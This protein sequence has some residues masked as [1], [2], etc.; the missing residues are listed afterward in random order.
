MALNNTVP[1]KSPGDLHYSSEVNEVTTFQKKQGNAQ[2]VL[3]PANILIDGTGQFNNYNHTGATLTLNAL[4]SVATSGDNYKKV[5]ITFTQDCTV[6]FTGEFDTDQLF[7]LPTGNVFPDGTYIFVFNHDQINSKVGFI[8]PG[9][10]GGVTPPVAE[11]TTFNGTT[12]NINFGDILD[13]IITGASARFAVEFEMKDYSESGY[14]AN[15]YPT[16]PNGQRQFGI[17]QFAGSMY[18]QYSIDGTGG[19]GSFNQCIWTGMTLLEKKVRIEF[20]ASQGGTFGIDK[21]TLYIDDVLYTTGKN[22]SESF[23]VSNIGTTTAQLSVGCSRNNVDVL[24]NF[25]TGF[26]KNFKVQNYESGWVDYINIPTL[27][28][29]VDESGKGN[30][31]T[32][33]P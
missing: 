13:S 18:F 20:D 9:T 2:G 29:P 17:G 26:M 1:D 6:S 33:T 25:W 14:P 22:M 27:S 24:A 12:T 21:A 7:G 16:S 4:A 28:T 15:K 5:K 10:G 11:W 30:N 23:T 32:F 19:A 8:S 31:G 3:D